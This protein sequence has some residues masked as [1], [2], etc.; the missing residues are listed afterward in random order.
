MSDK[1]DGIYP[2][3]SSGA[4][5]PWH[6]AFNRIARYRHPRRAAKPLKPR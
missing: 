1:R 2:E 4:S 6:A 5:T 3:A